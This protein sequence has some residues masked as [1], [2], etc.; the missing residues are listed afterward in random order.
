M[1]RH[2][3]GTWHFEV[4]RDYF[5]SLAQKLGLQYYTDGDELGRRVREIERVIPYGLYESLVI[6]LTYA[7]RMLGIERE[8]LTYWARKRYIT[9]IDQDDWHTPREE[10]PSKRSKTILVG[11]RGI[12]EANMINEFKWVE[13][14][15]LEAASEKARE[16]LKAWSHFR[17]DR[18]MVLVVSFRLEDDEHKLRRIDYKELFSKIIKSLGT[19]ILKYS[20][21]WGDVMWTKRPRIK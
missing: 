13:N 12:A 17:G 4:D 11:W 5:T 7:A 9:T 16:T 14:M 15:T 19:E 20:L 10:T 3:H 6:S 2:S 1:V 21:A 8:T 18:Y